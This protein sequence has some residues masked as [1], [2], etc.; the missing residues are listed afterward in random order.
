MTLGG[1]P[2]GIMNYTY[3]ENAQ[4]IFV[5]DFRMGQV[6]K[7]GTVLVG[8]LT[9]LWGLVVNFRTDDGQLLGAPIRLSFAEQDPDAPV[10]KHSTIW[11]ELTPL[12]QLARCAE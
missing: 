11:R 5:R 10:V 8:R 7:K 2:R 1:A 6:Y 3:I 12:E 4:I 9:K